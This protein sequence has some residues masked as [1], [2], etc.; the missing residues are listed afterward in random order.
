MNENPKNAK[1]AF[2][3]SSYIML[4]NDGVGLAFTF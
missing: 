2:I 3:E 4:N 1:T